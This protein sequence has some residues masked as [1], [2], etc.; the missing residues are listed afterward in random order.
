MSLYKCK[1][2]YEKRRFKS[3][4]KQYKILE[5]YIKDGELDI[6]TIIKEYSG[7]VYTSIKN[8]SNTIL[9]NED[10]EEIISDVFFFLWKN[11]DKLKKTDKVNFYL[12]GIAK[13]LLKE[14]Y[15]KQKESSN[16]DDYENYLSNDKTL[17]EIYEEKARMQILQKGLDSLSDND[18]KIFRLFYYGNKKSKEI[19]EELNMN[20]I[21][22]RSRLHRIKKQ[23]KKDLNFWRI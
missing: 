7:Y 10:I 6:E 19:A 14:K 8:M 2:S 21:T 22:V 5:D 12:V 11:K 18:R 23:I 20:E 13:N 1:I 15:R 16:I 4:L 3:K 17:D 9:S